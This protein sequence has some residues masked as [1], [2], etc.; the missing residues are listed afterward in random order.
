MA[1][2]VIEFDT[3]EKSLDVTMDGE[4]LQNVEEVSI[5]NAGYDRDGDGDEDDKDYHFHICMLESDDEHALRR[6]SKIVA[7]EV[8]Q[9]GEPLPNHPGLK[10][11]AGESKFE[12]D[13]AN[14]FKK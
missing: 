6:I 10:K 13:V 8:G 9:G 3:N 2:I 12:R 7:S 14:F 5:C 1:K 11:V 4:K